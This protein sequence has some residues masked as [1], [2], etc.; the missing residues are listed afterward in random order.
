MSK[1]S[2]CGYSDPYILTKG[3]RKVAGGDTAVAITTDRNNKQLVFKSSALFTN[4]ISRVKNA[5][6]NNAEDLVIVIPMYNLLEASL[7]QYCKS[8]PNNNITDSE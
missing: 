8:E 4:C 3:T 2:L 6:I 7:W 1:S 5:E